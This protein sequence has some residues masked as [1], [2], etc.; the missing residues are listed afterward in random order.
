MSRIQA[1]TLIELLIVIAI[2]AILG[3]ATVLVLNPVE[4]MSQA[5]DSQRVNDLGVI[6]KAVD[7]AIFSNPSI[8]TGTAQR[9]YLSLPSATAPNCDAAG[10]PNLPSGWQYVCSSAAN[11]SKI[12]GSGWLPVNFTS[13][14]NPNITSLPVDPVNSV[15]SGKYYTYVTGGS[16][17]LTAV[18]ESSK[19]NKA[20]ISD[21]GSLPG[22]LQ[23]G[24]HIDLTPPLRDKGLVGY[25]TFDEGGGTTVYDSSGNGNNGILYNSPSWQSGS[26]CESGS[27]ILFNGTNNYVNIPNSS[28]LNPK[29][30]SV[31][32]WMYWNG[33]VGEQNMVTKENS[34]E[35][36]VS[37]GSIN[38]ATNPWAWRGG[39]SPVTAGQWYHVVAV[40][41][42]NG[43]QKIYIN[44]VETYNTASGGDIASNASVVTIGAR[45]G[46][47]WSFYNGLL[48]EVRIYNRAL[49]AGE[50]LTI[51]NS[52][53]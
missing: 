30:I 51:Y 12:D 20:A 37:S 53:K 40:H 16:Y 38:Y 33:G 6:K 43:N 31:S 14:S 18:M 50:I 1:F 45:G 34:Y 23:V 41:Q 22:V 24:T 15:S 36:R 42:G 46:G 11:L 25:W 32:L 39:A 4:M 27:C 28:S 48:D 17:E 52:Q 35:Y 10:L 29:D 44:G 9:V 13:I 19:E 21:G 5:R 2:I 3:S 47:T 26:S 7:L 49:S 8:S